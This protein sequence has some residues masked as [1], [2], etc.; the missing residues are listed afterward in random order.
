MQRQQ[1]IAISATS[2][3]IHD[4]AYSA[5][6]IA[7][8][9][10]KDKRSALYSEVKRLRAIEKRKRK[11]KRKRE[12][13]AD[14]PREKKQRTLESVRETDATILAHPADDPDLHDDELVD[15]FAGY[16]AMREGPPKLLLTT[17]VGARKRRPTKTSKGQETGDLTGRLLQDL[18]TVFPNCHEEPRGERSMA[19]VVAAAKEGGYSAVL[20][21]NEDRG[22]PNG[23]LIC[24]LPHGPTALFKMTSVQPSSDILH[25]AAPSDHLPEVILGAFSTR[26]GH[27]VSRLLASLLPQRPEFGGRR[28]VTFHNQRDFIF[29]RHHR[30]VFDSAE[31]A[32][33]QE[34]G[35][36]FT[37][38]LRYLQH[39]AHDAK[40]GEYE[41]YHKKELITSR[42]RFFL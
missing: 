5:P 18:V 39:G 24:H 33:L 37:L 29:V 26:L 12:E 35:P 11:A 28:V 4:L 14:G 2:P 30:Y 7:H 27:S 13:D 9:K 40:H 42:R 10:Q 3:E 32:R 23:L 20:V 8:V 22:L 41:W 19:D 1:P 38:K 36:R 21:V 6:S 31:K 34:I 16:F 25:R 17:S 15:E